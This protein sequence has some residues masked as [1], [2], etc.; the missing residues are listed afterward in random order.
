MQNQSNHFFK[1]NYLAH[2]YLAGTQP[3]SIVG[4][5]IADHVKGSS[6]DAFSFGI[7]RGIA[8]HRGVD[9]FTDSHPFFQ[10]SAARLQPRYKHYS[11]VV[12]DMFY[13]HFLS[14][15]WQDYASIDLDVFLDQKFKI[16]T[17]FFDI[18]PPRA[19]RILPYMMEQNWLASYATFQGLN[20][21]L[22]G[23][24]RRTKFVS[25]MQYA[26]DDL[27]LHYAGFE[28]EFRSFFPELAAFVKDRYHPENMGF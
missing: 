25:N 20:Q 24:S 15:N 5:F 7:K 23:L 11:G 19:K 22:T 2:L 6:I 9:A 10:Q 18:L 16:L 27:K 26:V 17:S 3:E 4:N 14:K 1:L 12:V 28:S 13:D 8:M 21:A